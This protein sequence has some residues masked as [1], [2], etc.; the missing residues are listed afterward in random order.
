MRGDILTRVCPV[1]GKTYIPAPFHIY[2]VAGR[3]V[4][5]YSC[6]LQNVKNKQEK[7]SEK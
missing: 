7:G 4:C 1:C 5:S 6:S 2:K 3:K